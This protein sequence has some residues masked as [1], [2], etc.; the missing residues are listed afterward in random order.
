MTAV[1][2]KG[3]ILGLNEIRE[4]SRLEKKSAEILGEFA[5]ADGPEFH[6]VVLILL[7]FKGQKFGYET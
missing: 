4:I 1:I 3:S 6:D 2:N 7:G 5:H